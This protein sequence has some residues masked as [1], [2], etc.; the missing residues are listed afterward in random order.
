MRKEGVEGSLSNNLL[1]AG[2][3]RSDVGMVG[4]QPGAHKAWETVTEEGQ[5]GSRRF[6]GRSVLREKEEGKRGW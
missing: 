4:G 3:R 5:G 6:W 1:G 2:E